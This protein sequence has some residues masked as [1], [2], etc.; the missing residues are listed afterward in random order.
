MREEVFGQQLTAAAAVTN[1]DIS[2]IAFYSQDCLKDYG[3]RK[4][5]THEINKR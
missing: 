1:V 5:L 4:V 3:I 2:K